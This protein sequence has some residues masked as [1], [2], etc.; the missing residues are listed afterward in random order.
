MEVG[1]SYYTAWWIYLLAIVG[2]Q[3]SCW[4]LVRKIRNVNVKIV[5]QLILFGI[6]I[7]PAALESGQDYWVPAFMVAFMNS[8]DSGVEAALPQLKS[9]LWVT[10]MILVAFALTK[11]AWI[12]WISSPKKD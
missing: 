7:T 3:L 11:F 8:L 1:D 2:A 9:I 4:W 10:L 5:L 12:K 6:L